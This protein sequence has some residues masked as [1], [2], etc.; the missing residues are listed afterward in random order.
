MLYV[1]KSSKKI[2]DFFNKL[3][4]SKIFMVL[5]SMDITK[6]YL[7]RNNSNT[8]LYHSNYLTNKDSVIRNNSHE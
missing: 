4:I 5:C 3:R 7:E 2:Q 6:K 8:I 1:T